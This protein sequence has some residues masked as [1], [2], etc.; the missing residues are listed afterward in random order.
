MGLRD[1]REARGLLQEQLAEKS[2]VKVRS[3]R[4][5]EQGTLDINGAKLNTLLKLAKCLDCKV[6]DLLT[7]KETKDLY[8]NSI[9]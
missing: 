8:S 5:Y 7:D 6:L 4:A 2:G 1:I 9:F 3:I